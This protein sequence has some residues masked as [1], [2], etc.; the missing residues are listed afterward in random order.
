MT[1]DNIDEMTYKG[2]KTSQ[3]SIHIHHKYFIVAGKLASVCMAVAR[4]QSSGRDSRR[5]WSI[6]IYSFEFSNF[7]N[8]DVYFRRLKIEFV[9]EIRINSGVYRQ[10]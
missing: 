6:D 3:R 1:V 5:R 10:V 7:P 2:A 8:L 9:T 4:E